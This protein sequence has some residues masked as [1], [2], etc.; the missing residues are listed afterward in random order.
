MTTPLRFYQNNRAASDGATVT[1]SSAVS[2]FPGSNSVDERR[3]KRWRPQGAFLVASTNKKIYIADG[4]NKTITLTEA[5]YTSASSLASHIQTQLNASSSNWT[6]TWSSSTGKF[7]IG[8]SSGT[9]TL[10]MTQTTD[11]AW[12]MLGYLGSTDVSAGTGLAADLRRNHTSEKWTVDLGSAQDVTGFLAIGPSG[13]DYAP[14]SSATLTLKASAT[15]NFTSP[16]QTW[17]LTRTDRGVFEHFD[18]AVTYRYWQFEIRDLTNPLGPNLDQAVIYLGDHVGPASRTADVGFSRTLVDPSVRAFTE[19]GSLHSR[20]RTS[21]WVFRAINLQWLSD[22]DRTELERIVEELGQVTPFF[23]AL[24]PD[25][26]VSADASELTKY[27]V[28]DGDPSFTHQR[29]TYFAHEFAFRE[30]L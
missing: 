29:W 18:V 2:G 24:D 4:S 17:T 26:E 23:L 19:G 20:S 15:N 28:F 7:T 25:A 22:D 6:C 12:S 14:S 11:A 13:E 8:R 27:V 30:V 1:V 3:W 10:R 9:A 21:Y 5:T 16:D